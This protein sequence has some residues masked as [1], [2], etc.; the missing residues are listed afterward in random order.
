MIDEIDELIEELTTQSLFDESRLGIG[1]MSAG[2]MATLARLCQAHPFRCASVE[3]ATGSWEHQ[4]HREMF[5][6]RGRGEVAD[7][8]P[9][10][11]LEGWREIP[12]QAIHSRLDSWVAFEGQEAFLEE[13]AF[14]Y[15]RAELIELV[16][17]DE[18]GAPFEHAGFGRMSSDAKDRQRDFFKQ[19]LL[20]SV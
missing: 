1:G 12:V 20:D 18:T 6:G 14:H 2:G 7:H 13:L 15:Q 11:N 8:N 17:Y 3:A 5:Q 4:R 9:I 16:A 10:V 19:W